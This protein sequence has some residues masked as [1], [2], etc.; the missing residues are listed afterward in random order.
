MPTSIAI[1]VVF[2]PISV[3]KTAVI[4]NR[5]ESTPPRINAPTLPSGEVLNKRIIVIGLAL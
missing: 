4:P 5:I 3:A 2:R 1:S